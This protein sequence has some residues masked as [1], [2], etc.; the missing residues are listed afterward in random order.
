MEKNMSETNSPFKPYSIGLFEGTAWYYA[1]FRTG[2]PEESIDFLVER[3][4]LNSSTHVLDLGTGTGQIAIP[5]ALRGIPVIAVDPD[6]E[7]LCEGLHAEHK[8]G[9]FGIS[10]IRGNDKLLPSLDIRPV[11]LCTMGASFHWTDRDLLLRILDSLIST[12]GAVAILSGGGSVWSNSGKEWMEITKAVVVEFL[13]SERRAGTGIY[14]HPNERHETVLKRSPFPKVE[15]F[16]FTIESEITVDQ[17]IGLQLSTSYASPLHL[18]SRIEEFRETLRRRLLETNISG[19]F[20]NR[21]TAELF[22]ARR[23]ESHVI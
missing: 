7:M 16:E 2:Y 19:V 14:N 1:R 20:E 10:W 4:G 5:L 6:V 17:I 15:R 8:A 11:K 13:G 22:L 9:T 12:D 3:V 23:E 18:G 21:Q